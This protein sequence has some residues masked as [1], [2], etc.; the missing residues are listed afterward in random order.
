MKDMEFKIGNVDIT[1]VSTELPDGKFDIEVRA[2]GD[3]AEV[4]KVMREIVSGSAH[5]DLPIELGIGE[6]DSPLKPLKVSE[7]M[8]GN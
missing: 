7:L 5:H 8:G 2:T 3:K 6:A 4:K 1:I